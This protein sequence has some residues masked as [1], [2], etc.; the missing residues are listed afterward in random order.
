MIIITY[1]LLVGDLPEVVDGHDA[2]ED[3]QGLQCDYNL[4]LWMTPHSK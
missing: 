4:L 1:V 2:E 3:D